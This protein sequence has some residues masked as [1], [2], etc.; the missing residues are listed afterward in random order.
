MPKETHPKVV[1]HHESAA[2]ARPMTAEHHDQSDDE[3]AHRHLTTAREHSTQAP[4][5]ST[6]ARRRSG[7]QRPAKK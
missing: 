6:A 2:K 5:H 3:T 1:E 4:R 7:E